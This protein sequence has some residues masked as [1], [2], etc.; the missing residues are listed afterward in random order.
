MGHKV[1]PNGLR[2]GINKDW[3]SR[4]YATNDN[5]LAKWILEDHKIRKA[6]FAHLITSGVS[7]IEIERTKS[8]I[9]LFIHC[10]RVG[11]ALGQGGANIEVL[12]TLVRKT[13]KNRKI[14]I[15]INV[16][17]IKNPDIDAQIIANTLAQQIS[18]RMS[19]RTTQKLAIR[20]ALRAGAKGIKTRVSGRLGEADMAREEGYSEN[21][22]PLATLRSNI[23]YAT[24]TAK[25]TFGQIGIKVWVYKG[26]ILFGTDTT[27]P[28][29]LSKYNQRPNNNRRANSNRSNDNNRAKSTNNRPRITKEVK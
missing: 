25:T 6:L 3:Q 19:H 17:E 14:G 23:D 21:S 12:T 29:I 2:Y 1:S 10:V 13:I 4:W 28:E 18:A 20:K 15:R 16:M 5:D 26:E 24:A 22:V 9:T 27:Q 7:K 8:Q 11:S